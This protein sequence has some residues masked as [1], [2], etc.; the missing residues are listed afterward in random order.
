[1][2]T[3][4][5]ETV[6][7]KISAGERIMDISRELDVPRSNIYYWLKH[8]EEFKA[9]LHRIEQMT[10]LQAQQYVMY[11]LNTYLANIDRIANLTDGD[12]R[13]VQKA[14]E[15]MVN[16][17]LGNPTN[18]IETNSNDNSNSVLSDEDLDK[19]FDEFDQEQYNE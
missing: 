12:V 1:M 9:E 13:T 14:N 19:E 10:K 4:Q 6:V 2:L 5:Q 3:K 11:R 8:D 18:I 16:R 17:V 7:A 15:Y